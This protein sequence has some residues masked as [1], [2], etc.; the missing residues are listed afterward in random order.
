MYLNPN[1]S[2]SGMSKLNC[3]QPQVF[4][5]LVFMEHLMKPAYIQH[6]GV[7]KAISNTCPRFIHKSL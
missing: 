1:L 3:Q 4:I 5:Q 6:R 7:H 2:H